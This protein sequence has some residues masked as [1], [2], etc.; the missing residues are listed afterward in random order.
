MPPEVMRVRKPTSWTAY[1]E[2]G[3]GDSEAREEEQDAARDD[4]E[5]L[6][7]VPVTE[8]EVRQLST[9]FRWAMVVK[10]ICDA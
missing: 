2:D 4:E 9:E 6:T 5:I 10:E 8:L 1:A 7:R 3:G